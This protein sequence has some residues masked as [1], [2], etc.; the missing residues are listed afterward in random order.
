MKKILIRTAIVVVV[1]VA[2]ITLIASLYIDSVARSLIHSQGTAALGVETSVESASIGLISSSTT[3]S[4]LTVDNPPGFDAPTLIQ[5]DEITTDTT[6][7]AFMPPTIDI[8][9]LT[10]TGVDLDLEQ[11]DG[12][13]NLESVIDHLS[14]DSDDASEGGDS[15]VELTIGTLQ[16]NDITV[17]AKGKL[18]LLASGRIDAEIP[19]ITLHDIGTRTDAADV[20]K[21]LSSI[22]VGAIVEQL[23]RDPIK[24]LSGAFI[25]SISAS[26][27]SIPILSE[28]GLGRKL[29]D[30]LNKAGEALGEGIGGLGEKLGEGLKGL[31]DA[32]QGGG[33]NK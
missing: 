6:V 1:M 10:I 33:G 20:A 19:S 7:W 31:G 16:I 26:I 4:G 3:I 11:T 28:I 9:T 13:S 29:E 14:T 5:V 8:P 23:A 2:A 18:V 17:H 25:G 12:R 24:G 27:D 32:L 21:Q 30:T 15:S 22:I